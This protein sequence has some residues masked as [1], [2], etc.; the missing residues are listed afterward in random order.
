MMAESRVAFIQ[1]KYGKANLFSRAFIH[2][3]MRD[4]GDGFAIVKLYPKGVRGFAR[5]DAGFD[6]L[7]GLNLILASRK[8]PELISLLT[9]PGAVRRW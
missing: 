9:L 2:D 4:Y 3:Y 1:L 7:M 6:D 5:Y 8:C